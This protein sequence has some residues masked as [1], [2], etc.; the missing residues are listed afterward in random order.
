MK[1]IIL[2]LVSLYF[3]TS[4]EQ[5]FIPAVP[6]EERIII[7]GHIESGPEAL[8]PYVI[9]SR[10][11]PYFGVVQPE[12]IVNN[13]ITDAQV[14][15]IFEGSAYELEHFCIS[16]LPPELIE[17]LLGEADVNFI[18][19]STDF[20]LYI[21][22]QNSIPIQVG[23]KYDLNI[24]LANGEQLTGTTTIPNLVPLDSFEFT[25]P[26]GNP[27]ADTLARLLS[28]L[29]DPADEVNFY[30]YLT[31]SNEGPFIAGFGSVVDDA[32]F[33][34]QTFQ[35]P[36]Q[37]AIDP[38]ANEE[39]DDDFETETFGLYNRGDTIRIKWMNLDEEH[40]NFWN[41]FEFNLNNQ[42]PFSTYTRVSSNVDGALGVWGGYSSDIYTLVVPTQ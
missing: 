38:Q 33:N 19:D 18:L 15:V 41:S 31:A 6:E 30:R 3:L 1:Y 2:T 10:S 25:P 39:L 27:E 42:G 16:D 35:F 7:E 22:W 26:P 11:L 29:S 13:Q 40:F 28:Y 34:G 37:K 17:G 32:L 4:C 5:V 8:P 24:Q 20:C 21:D 36:L 9:L 12:D 23:G 14:E